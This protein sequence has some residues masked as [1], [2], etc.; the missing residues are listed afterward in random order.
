MRVG[1][2]S[3]LKWN[4]DGGCIS[5]NSTCFHTELG[6]KEGDQ[7][8]DRTQ[9]SQY[10]TIAHAVPFSDGGDAHLCFSR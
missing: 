2:G 6:W 1:G 8:E 7:G 4:R 5:G 3:S 10:L 9:D